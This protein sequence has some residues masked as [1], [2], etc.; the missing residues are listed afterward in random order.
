[1]AW[2]EISEE[3][4]LTVLAGAEL[5]AYRAAALQAGQEDPVEPTIRNVANLVRGYVGGCKNNILGAGLTIPEKLLAPALDILAVAIPK[6][7][8]ATPKPVRKDAHDAAI[9]LLEMVAACKFDIEEP[10]EAT[11]ETSSGQSPASAA[12]TLSHS[13]ADQDG[14]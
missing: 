7:V 6:R 8:G 9:K 3:D 11:T 10:E 4:L 14:I 1:M 13:R 12:K 2:I 5:S